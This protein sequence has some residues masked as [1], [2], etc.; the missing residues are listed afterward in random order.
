ML[1]IAL[2]GLAVAIG[3]LA[4][5]FSWPAVLLAGLSPVAILLFGFFRVQSSGQVPQWPDQWILPAALSFLAASMFLRYEL[6]QHMMEI[7]LVRTPPA[8]LWHLWAASIF[9]GMASGLYFRDCWGLAGTVALYGLMSMACFYTA[10]AMLDVQLDR[11]APV[12][13]RLAR[14][15]GKEITSNGRTSHGTLKLDT[16]EGTGLPAEYTGSWNIY[17]ALK[18]GDAICF[19]EYPGALGAPWRKV[20]A[21]GGAN[22]SVR[23]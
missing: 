2:S 11:Q 1:W 4:F 10:Y 13:V 21:C 19:L 6:S 18:V 12:A 3:L 23:R 15:T 5:A 22:F 17:Q 20:A 7:G 8:A 9:C 14:I 16:S